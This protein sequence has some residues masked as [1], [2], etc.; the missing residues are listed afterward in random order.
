MHL[1]VAPSREA[2]VLFDRPLHFPCARHAVGEHNH[3]AFAHGDGFAA[4][5]GRDCHLALDDVARLGA[6][7]GPLKLGRGA[8]LIARIAGHRARRDDEKGSRASRCARRGQQHARP[9]AARRRCAHP[10]WPLRHPLDLARGR[11]PVHLDLLA[12]HPHARQGPR[13]LRSGANAVWCERHK[14]ADDARGGKHHAGFSSFNLP[15]LS[16]C[17]TDWPRVGGASGDR[18]TAAASGRG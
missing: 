10:S 1:V 11:R 13:R 6:R 5:V 8:A 15:F 12:A 9:A 16:D 17:A 18:R 7:V 14:H 4:I 3:V 2:V